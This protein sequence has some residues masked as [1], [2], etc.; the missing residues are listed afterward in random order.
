[1]RSFLT[2]YWPLTLAVAATTLLTLP[3][4]SQTSLT[5]TAADLPAMRVTVN[6]A[7]DGSVQ[8]DEKLTLREAIEIV[9]GSLA[10]SALSDRESAQI[11]ELP[12]E[13]NSADANNPAA[14][15]AFDLPP[16]QTVIYLSTRLPAISRS[17]VVIDGTTQPGYAADQ[18][19]TAEIAIPVPV[20]EITAAAEAEVFRGLTV[21]ASG[22]TIR[23]L[24]LYGFTAKHR[25]TEVTPPADIFIAHPLAPLDGSDRRLPAQGFSFYDADTPPEDVTI[26]YNWLGLPPDESIPAVPSAFGVSVFNSR[27]TT[28]YRNR[29]A[30]HDGS[31]IITGARAE[32]LHVAE[33]ILVANGLRGMPD[34]IRLEGRIDRS[35]ISGNLVCGNDGSGIFLFKPEGSVEIRDN[36]IKF[37]GQR[38]RRAAIYLMGDD[39]QVVDNSIT[40]QKGPGVVVTAFASDRL[41]PSHRNAIQNNRFANLEGLSIDLNTRRHTGVQD[42]Q[43]GDGVN[44]RR[45]SAN[46]RLD[47]ANSAINAPQFLSQ[48]FYILNDQVVIAGTADPGSE[49]ELYL[50]QGQIQAYGPLNAPIATLQPNAAGNFQFATN[51][52]KP[53]D[54]ISAIATDPRYGTSEPALNTVIKSLAATAAESAVPNQDLGTPQC[55]TRPQPPTPVAAIPVP[56][57][58]IQLEVPR[59]IHFGLDQASI[60]AESTEILNQIV[61]AMK[62]HSTLVV[63]LHGHTDSRASSTYN[64]ELA[65]RRAHNTRQYLIAQGIDPARITLRSLG[66][67][68]LRVEE[69][70]RADYARNRR[71]EFVFQDVRG[72][73]A[74]FVHQES[75][76]QLEP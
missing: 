69:S 67:T 51:N 25:A 49:I 28:L 45:N 61:E 53:G 19:A 16:G 71:V 32:G 12:V 29:I 21:A 52:L 63:D 38:L 15:V 42:F 73:D 36:D 31:A 59:N 2:H 62:A 8:A 1:M 43:R 76:L 24:S 9:N 37:N 68:Q 22:V 65:L 18:S 20:V 54:V 27:G 4:Q 60:S 13:A 23:A 17:G 44:P 11:S 10:L 74:T 46:R 34:A 39:H 75:D 6:S 64:Q 5:P 35:L 3:A 66:E 70:D 48:E 50:S 47:T 72:L 7:A 30:Y 56:P 40:N 57:A 58:P 55:T 14:I 33:N 41:S 26:E